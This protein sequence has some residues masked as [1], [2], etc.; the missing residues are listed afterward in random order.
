[1]MSGLSSIAV[2]KNSNLMDLLFMWPQYCF[3]LSWVN[4]L[5]FCLFI[6]LFLI[7]LGTKERANQLPRIRKCHKDIQVQLLLS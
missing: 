2:F 1:M 4:S 7:F 6:Y 5:F 3:V